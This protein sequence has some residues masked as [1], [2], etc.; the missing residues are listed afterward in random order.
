MSNQT[1]H[2]IIE[3]NACRLVIADLVDI[4]KD[5]MCD[6]PMDKKHVF[7]ILEEASHLCRTRL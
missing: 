5:F 2:E 6:Q 4:V 7:R 3:I 1:V